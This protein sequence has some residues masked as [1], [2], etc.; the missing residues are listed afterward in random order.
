MQSTP[1]I[2]APA[3]S[4]YFVLT[5][6]TYNGNLG[7]MAGANAKCLL[8]LATTSTGWQGHAA[9]SSNG[10]LVAG[11]VFAFLVGAGNN[12]LAALT[13][14]YFANA[15]DASAGGA[16]FTTD[17][18]GQGPGDSSSW[19]AANY[20]SGT[21]DY[22]SARGAGSST[23]WST[24]TNGTGRYCSSWA[25]SSSVV[26][27]GIGDAAWTNGGRWNGDSNIACDTQH[28]LICFV[29]P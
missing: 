9:A 7:G 20:F 4:G 28:R 19:A 27:G 29:N 2:T 16:S 18:S 22:W 17:A 1:V 3:G 14:Y 11:K 12:N 5:A 25:S 21:Y 8:E 13:T 24:G 23:L 10:Q 15:G 6:T 26:I